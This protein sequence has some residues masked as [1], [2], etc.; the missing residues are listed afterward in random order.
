[1]ADRKLTLEMQAA[2]RLKELLTA[3]YGDDTDLLRDSIEGET[4]LHKAI[5][6]AAFDLAVVEGE[7]DGIEIAIAK[8]KERLTRHCNKATGIRGAI[9]AAMEIAE[10][11][12]LKTPAATLSVKAN[13]ASVEITD[14][15]AI[16]A[17]FMV[18]PPLPPARPDKRAI[19]D[20]LK[21]KQDVPGAVLSN[22]PPSLQVRYK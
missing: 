17:V 22:Q 6:N 16:P 4:N 3:A 7:K 8:M 10:L 1:M 20:A 18:Q 21:S 15:A 13:P 11:S 19:A 5:C 9:Q 14:E 2:A 12:S